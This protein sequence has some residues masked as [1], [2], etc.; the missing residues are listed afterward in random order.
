MA[1]EKTPENPKKTRITAKQRKAARTPNIYTTAQIKQM[2]ELAFEGCQNNTIARIMGINEDTMLRYV[3]EKLQ[4]K[5]AERRQWLR[6]KQ[7]K[8]INA[9]NPALL[10]FVGKNELDQADKK[11]LKLSGDLTVNITN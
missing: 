6:S 3:K 10:I 11:D 2:Q 1:K 5:R 4:Q 9:G 7:N 8:A